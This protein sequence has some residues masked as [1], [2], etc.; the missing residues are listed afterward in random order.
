MNVFTHHNKLRLL[1][2]MIISLVLLAVMIIRLGY[3]MIVKS[4]HYG[5]AAELIQERERSIKAPRGLIYDRNGVVIADNKAVCSISVIHSQI[6]DEEKVIDVLSD[7]LELDKEDIRK[8]VEKVS[9]REKIKS[10]V[11][12]E[13]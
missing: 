1:Q 3:I 12:K 9:S 5:E 11:D 7:K 10:N 6:T 4:N 8:K 13:V 2:F